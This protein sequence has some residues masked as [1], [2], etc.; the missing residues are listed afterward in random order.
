MLYHWFNIQYPDHTPADILTHFITANE[1]LC[2]YIQYVYE[3][4]ER[5]HVAGDAVLALHQF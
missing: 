4:K 3:K 5:L 2:P 1:V